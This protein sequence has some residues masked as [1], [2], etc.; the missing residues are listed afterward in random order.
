MKARGCKAIQMSDSY[1]CTSC[2]LRW[3]MNDPEPPECKPATTE[4]VVEVG[5]SKFSAN[6]LAFKNN[7][8]LIMQKESCKK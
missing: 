1:V 3:D 4:T 6:Y 2:G 5:G 8:R 7:L